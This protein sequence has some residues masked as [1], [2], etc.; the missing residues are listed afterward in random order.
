MSRN[1]S[2]QW[3]QEKQR[4]VFKPGKSPAQRSVKGHKRERMCVKEWDGLIAKDYHMASPCSTRTTH[5]LWLKRSLWA[6]RSPTLLLDAPAHPLE[7]N[8]EIQPPTSFL[9]S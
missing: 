4:Y 9:V 5:L 8:G 3:L 7:Y 1:T 6:G 2:L